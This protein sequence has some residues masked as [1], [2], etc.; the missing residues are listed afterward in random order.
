MLTKPAILLHLES[1]AIF[2]LSIFFY[3]HIHAS[4]LLFGL[5]FLSPDL[6]LLGYLAH[7]RVGAALYNFAHTLS[8]PSLLLAVGFLTG[9]SELPPF[10]LIWTAHIGF[11]R[12][13]GYG[14]KYPTHF[15]DTSACLTP[16]RYPP[17]RASSSLL[18]TASHDSYFGGSHGIT[19]PS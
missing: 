1:V 10:V 14:L 16:R 4:W 15:K 8:T 12:L 2:L 18:V 19:S 13:L 5:L 3:R 7:A 6:F 9:W 11:D 17:G